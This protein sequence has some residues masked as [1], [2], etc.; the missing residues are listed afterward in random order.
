MTALLSS[1]HSKGW[2]VTPF[3]SL[4]STVQAQGSDAKMRASRRQTTR[5]QMTDHP[6]MKRRQ[7]RWEEEEEEDAPDGDLTSA[8]TAEEI[9]RSTTV[10]VM[11]GELMPP[12]PLCCWLFFEFAEWPDEERIERTSDDEVKEDEEYDDAEKEEEQEDEEEQLSR[13]QEG[14]IRCWR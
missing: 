12:A 7:R 11:M 6:E 9:R 13:F 1:K 2:M 8:L 4:A 5:I 10:E 14:S 3:L